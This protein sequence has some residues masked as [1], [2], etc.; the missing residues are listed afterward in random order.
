MPLPPSFE[1]KL[2]RARAI[3]RTVRELE[4]ERGEGLPGAGGARVG[5]ERRPK[6][7]ARRVAR[8]ARGLR[9]IV[10]RDRR[11]EREPGREVTAAVEALRARERVV[12]VADAVR[13]EGP[14]EVDEGGDGVTARGRGR[15]RREEREGRV[16]RGERRRP[17]I[18][19]AEAFAVRSARAWHDDEP[20]LG[21]GR[22]S[23]SMSGRAS[24]TLRRSSRSRR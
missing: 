5:R 1:A 7:P 19:E 13:G 24:G 4:L 8:E 9:R 2:V 15:R 6:T 16:A 3:S 23:R 20:E 22:I 12:D 17:G 18:D 14:A 11:G 10:A 21:S